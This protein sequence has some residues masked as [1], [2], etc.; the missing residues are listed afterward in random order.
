MLH[1]S[2]IFILLFICSFS[3][4]SQ[5]QKKKSLFVS[6][7]SG[8]FITSI[9][10]FEDTYDSQAGIVY[11]LGLGLPLSTKAF[12]YGKATLFSKNGTPVF[13]TYRFENG[14][15]TLID[16]TREGSASFKQWIINGGILYNLLNN[17]I[18]ILGVNGGITYSKISEEIK[19]SSGTTSS[20]VNG[21]G[22]LGFFGGVVIEK[23]FDEKPISVFIDTQINITR[24]DV[25]SYVGNYGGI[26]L[27][28]G[29]RY[30][31]KK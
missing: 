7:H 15:T 18:W 14:E 19:N 30:F 8:L 20:S 6:I 10:N 26:N 23:K 4:Y 29:V 22:I 11:G 24:S 21:S 16:E 13:R 17:R 28:I 25:L 2:W 31:F 9:E 3:I 12:I 5:T 1:K 27:N